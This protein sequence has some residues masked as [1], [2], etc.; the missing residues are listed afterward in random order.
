VAARAK[1]GLWPWPS[2]IAHRGAGTLAPE[3]TLAAMRRALDFGFHAV[4]F[5]VMLAADGVPVLMHDA[6]FGR[7]VAGSGEVS[8]TPS[9]QLLAMDAGRWHSS[10]Y[11]GERV[12]AYAEV[13]RFCMDHAI[14]MNV[15]IKPAP[16][17]E[18]Q[19]GAV[20]AQ[21]TN[22]LFDRTP[23]LAPL[24]SSF[25][26]VA[27]AAAR[28]VAPQFSRGLLVGALPPDWYERAARTAC[29]AVHCNHQHLDAVQ[30]SAIKKAS[31]GLLCYTVN[32]V[33]RARELR[34]WGV[35]AI[36]TDRPDLFV[37][38]TGSESEPLA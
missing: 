19:T 1:R 23:L 29:V 22:A 4:E 36:C 13:L 33:E 10:E 31:Y 3:N 6:R 15:E 30:V 37:A 12:P 17:Y 28:E 9:A 16:G 27:L 32:S 24:F 26:D 11:A 20:V 5:D 8:S 25:S 21:V 18:R 35:D 14:W 2:H 38:R 7:T 34:S